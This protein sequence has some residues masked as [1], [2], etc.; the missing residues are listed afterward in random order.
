MRS[1]TYNIRRISLNIHRRLCMESLRRYANYANNADICVMR[2]TIISHTHHHPSIHTYISHTNTSHTANNIPS[3]RTRTHTHRHTILWTHTHTHT[4]TVIHTH[5]HPHTNIAIVNAFVYILLCDIRMHTHH[6]HIT[7]THI[8]HTSH[9]HHMHI[10]HTSHWQVKCH[11]I[12]TVQ[13]LCDLARKL[14]NVTEFAVDLEHH[15]YRTYLGIVCLMQVCG[16]RVMCV[17]CVCD[18]CVMCVWCVCDVRVMCV[19]CVWS[20][21]ISVF[22]FTHTYIIHPTS[23]ITPHIIHHTSHI[24]HI[25]SYIIVLR[26]LHAQMI[27][28]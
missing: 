5:T 22:M 3:I 23:Y 8:T 18:V 24:I 26:S 21:S 12:N 28:S 7:H 17:W 25:T 2:A 16:V 4:H 15:S 20:T 13:Q 14:D 10:T 1:Q 6:T 11:Y 27:T 9:T 19:W